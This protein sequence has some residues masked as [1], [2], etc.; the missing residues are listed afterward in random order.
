MLNNKLLFDNLNQ[1]FLENNWKRNICDNCKNTFYTKK[2]LNTCGNLSCIKKY[3]FLDFPRKKGYSFIDDI[4]ENVYN[5]F[6]NKGYKIKG[7]QSIVNN[8]SKT[9]FIGAGVQTLDKIIFNEEEVISE[10][11]FIAQPSIRT[12]FMNDAGNVEGIS[13]SFVN[14]C[15]EE[16]TDSE[17]KYIKHLDD[18]LSYLSNAGIFVGDATITIKSK[19][20]NWGK[21]DFDSFISHLYYGGLDIGDISFNY[22]IPQKSRENLSVIDAGFGLERICWAVNKTDSYFDCIGPLFDSIQGKSK[23]IDSVRTL[24]LMAGFGVVPSNKEQGYRFR[25]FSKILSEKYPECKTDHL[26]DYYY[27]YWENFSR[28]ILTKEECKNTIQTEIDR[29]FILDLSKYLEAKPILRGDTEN[30]L[31]DLIN[32]GY[33]FHKMKNKLSNYRKWIL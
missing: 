32:H 31:K 15:T 25:Q 14:V 27:N 21:G 10:P 4:K 6:K 22:N 5:F 28:F 3:T 12:Q 33:H 7:G 19:I 23:I 2:D 29:N 16:F 20:K 13:S 11:F 17:N 24:V 9:L 30:F 8:L 18:W 1:Y 26:I